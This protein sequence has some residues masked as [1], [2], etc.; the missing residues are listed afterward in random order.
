VIKTRALFGMLII[1][2][3]FLVISGCDPVANTDGGGGGD[4]PDYQVH[5]IQ[6]VYQEGNVVVTWNANSLAASYEVLAD[7]GQTGSYVSLGTVTTNSYTHTGVTQNTYYA[8]KVNLIDQDGVTH[9]G[10]ESQWVSTYPDSGGG[11]GGGTGTAEDPILIN[12]Y[13]LEN[14]Y[15]GN[16]VQDEDTWYY[17]D[18]TAGSKLTI[19]LNDADSGAMSYDGNARFTF[20]RADQATAYAG[21]ENLDG[22]NETDNIVQVTLATGETRIYIK[23]TGVATGSFSFWLKEI[24]V[25]GVAT[26]G[27]AGVSVTG[28]GYGDLGFDPGTFEYAIPIGALVTGVTVTFTPSD[29]GATVS[30]TVDD[31]AVDASGGSISMDSF[32]LYVPKVLVITVASSDGVNTNDYAFTVTKSSNDNTLTNL[33]FSDETTLTDFSGSQLSVT[34]DA[35]IDTLTVTPNAEDEHATILVN[36]VEVASGSESTPVSIV[37]GVNTDAFVIEIWAP[38]GSVSNSYYVTVEKRLSGDFDLLVDGAVT[39][40]FDDATNT[41]DVTLPIGYQTAYLQLTPLDTTAVVLVNGAQTTSV[42]VSLAGDYLTTTV[43]VSVTP[44]SGNGTEE[45]F[46]INIRPSWNADSPQDATTVTYRFKASAGQ[47]YAISW[48]DNSDDPDQ[49]S[50]EIRVSAFNED[51]SA[52]SAVANAA[53]GP[54]SFTSAT[55]QLVS[56]ELTALDGSNVGTYAIMVEEGSAGSGT[57]VTFMA[58]DDTVIVVE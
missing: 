19:L 43:S 48:M 30:A 35:T 9:E 17:V 53:S 21:F 47:S 23:F 36:G 49:W 57:H 44:D 24:A 28:G 4:Q 51:D 38:D 8:Y 56:V 25:S 18:V 52:I 42:N 50:E 41:Y 7:Q 31:I 37:V 55:D 14:W 33:V 54:V 40:S 12:D 10:A 13:Q 22:A 15:P 16:A 3:S 32:T 45:T 2:M 5:G 11:G 39:Q 20:Y 6:P 46:T 1:M 29:F 58:S 34:V 26:L 27:Y